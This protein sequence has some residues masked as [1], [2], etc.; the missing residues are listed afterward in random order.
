MTSNN[1]LIPGYPSN[2]SNNP[3]SH[4]ESD[5]ESVELSET[6]GSN[7]SS[8][9]N[10]YGE[11][12][13]VDSLDMISNPSAKL[14]DMF[15]DLSLNDLD[16]PED[17]NQQEYQQQ[18]IM[19]IEESEEEKINNIGE[20]EEEE[21]WT[22]EERDTPHELMSNLPQFPRTLSRVSRNGG[23]P[24]LDQ[25]IE[26]EKE[27][28][29][30]GEEEE[31][32]NYQPYPSLED[33]QQD[34]TNP[35]NNPPRDSRIENNYIQDGEQEE[36]IFEEEEE[37]QDEEFDQY[38]QYPII[39][40]D[41][42]SDSETNHLSE[43]TGL[44]DLSEVENKLGSLHDINELTFMASMVDSEYDP[45]HEQ[46]LLEEIDSFLKEKPPTSYEYMK[47]R[48]AE[49]DIV[50]LRFIEYLRQRKLEINIKDAKKLIKEKVFPR[51]RV[52]SEKILERKEKHISHIKALR[53]HSKFSK[54]DLE[55]FKN[56]NIELKKKVIH[57]ET[58]IRLL[59]VEL[60]KVQKLDYFPNKLK[61]KFMEIDA[62]KKIIGE[63]NN[64]NYKEMTLVNDKKQHQRRQLL[65]YKTPQKR[66]KFNIK[67]SQ[68]DTQ[69]SSNKFQKK[70]RPSSQISSTST[71]ASITSIDTESL[72]IQNHQLKQEINSQKSKFKKE[73]GQMKAIY[74]QYLKEL[75]TK[76]NEMAS[77][78]GIDKKP[79][80]QST[81]LRSKTKPKDELSQARIKIQKLKV[82]IEGK[83]K[84]IEVWKDRNLEINQKLERSK[85]S[86]TYKKI[87]QIQKK[88]EVNNKK[89]DKIEK[90]NTLSFHIQKAFG[91]KDFPF[92]NSLLRVV[93]KVQKLFRQPISVVRKYFQAMMSTF[94]RFLVSPVT[95]VY[96]KIDECV[97]LINLRLRKNT[98]YSLNKRI[99]SWKKDPLKSG[100]DIMFLHREIELLEKENTILEEKVTEL[101]DN[102]QEMKMKGTYNVDISSKIF[103]VLLLAGKL[104][105]KK[106]KHSV[107]RIKEIQEAKENLPDE[108]KLEIQ[109]I[110][111]KNYA[112][113]VR[114]PPYY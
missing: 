112:L 31:E 88:M 96:H 16:E 37:F 20:E 58:L 72:Q 17:Y 19:E 50:E 73:I 110:Y 29:F 113:K 92:I 14:S 84:E 69:F 77:R 85:K 104:I 93:K 78:S 52:V 66:S 80:H 103:W 70:K 71:R 62:I 15:G 44:S 107:K 9:K 53:Q 87:E 76:N 60:V 24:S 111:L 7:I 74:E 41:S 33:Y 28:H 21:Q 11:D 13:Y 5:Y 6:Q 98:D 101:V 91:K 105:N 10:A 32:G 27:P 114:Y 54:G 34:P 95:I 82:V 18:P 83:N 55:N 22:D 35:S 39:M 46:V 57:L 47:A 61:K 43:I 79:C 56:D 38:E 63:Q 48:Q 67:I 2:P 64:G 30:D 97:T 36:E 94:L 68:N 42:V 40:E 26:E 86:I 65:P 49:V 100:T 45:Q 25:I 109:Q 108:L 12:E 23:L 102:A 99:D 89:M 51:L 106:F 4:P 1:P 8:K 75:N 81:T 59:K 90:S 3:I